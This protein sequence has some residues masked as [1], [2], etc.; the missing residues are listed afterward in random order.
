MIKKIFFEYFKTFFLAI[1]TTIVTVFLILAIM[2]HQISSEEAIKKQAEDKTLDLQMIELLIEKNKY[3]IEQHPE[4]YKL[5]SK[6]GFLYETKKDY[7]NAE[8]E[9]KAAISKVP[10]HEFKPYY[11][12]SAFYIKQGQLEKA[13]L[14]MDNLGE[15]P[16]KK[17][18]EFKAEIYEQLGDKYY[19]KADYHESA[20]KYQKALNYYDVI[21]SKKSIEKKLR[22][23][24]ASSYVY[25]ADEKVKEMNVDEAIAYLNMAKSIINA[26]I[27]AYK[28]GLLLTTTNPELANKY[29]EE[30]FEKEPALINYDEYY[31]LLSSLANNAEYDGDDSTAE[32]YKFKIKKIK[33]YYNENLLAVADIEITEPTG[34]ILVNKW[35]KKYKMDFSFALKNISKYTLNSL[36]LN[37]VFKDGDEIIESFSKQIIEGTIPL[38]SGEKIPFIN[39]KTT[40][41]SFIGDCPN[42]IT[43]QVY[44]SKKEDSRQLLLKELVIKQKPKVKKSKSQLEL[45]LQKYVLRYI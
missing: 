9:Y 6:L 24:L 29:F 4:D 40:E 35:F 41:K 10:Y 2:L 5:D 39:I 34:E 15:K 23:N 1:L 19:D 25:L 31:K 43:V 38:K 11:D 18:V 36:Y 17:L 44:A 14:I 7:Q 27:I 33:K 32:L 45:F 22:G 3:L 21:K 26:P 13:Q 12:L 20:L 30:V 8:L 28:L 16:S 37:I 42:E